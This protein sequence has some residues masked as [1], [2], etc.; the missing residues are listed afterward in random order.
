M[1]LRK[2][3]L[4]AMSASLA[5]GAAIDGSWTAE[6]KMRGSKK[7]GAQD[8]TVE[9]RMNLKADGEKPTGTVIS[10]AR[11]KGVA[12]KIV[13]GKIDGNQFSFTTV[14]T[15]KKGQQ[16]FEWRGTVNGDTLQGTRF[17][18]GAKRGQDFTAKRG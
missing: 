12:A 14:Q 16:T 5:F 2:L 9:I 17:R 8:R 11:K 18:V 3:L 13:D 4:F 15:T 1:R 10:G 7:T 6:I